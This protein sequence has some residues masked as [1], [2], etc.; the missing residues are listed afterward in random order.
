MAESSLRA[1]LLHFTRDAV[2]T[3]D[4]IAAH[5]AAVDDVGIQR[6]G[7][8][9]RILRRAY[10]MPFAERDLAIV[11][12][13]GDARRSA[14][15]LPAIDP[16][17]H[18]VVGNHVIK[19]RGRLVVPGTPGA[20][21]VHADG[22]ALVESQQDDV[23]ILR[24]DPDGVIVVAA[25]RA[26]DGREARAGVGGPVSGS[27]GDVDHVLVLRVDTHAGEIRSASVDA[28]L[29]V[30]F[31]PGNAGVIGAIEAG[32]TRRGF[33][34][35]RAARASTS[36]ARATRGAGPTAAATSAATGGFDQGIH[37]IAIAG[38]DADADAAEPL[39]GRGQA[40]SQLA[41]VVAAVGGL[42]QAAVRT[43]ESAVL[44]WPGTRLP[45]HGVHVARVGRVEGQINRAG[46]L[47]L[48]KNLAPVLAAIDGAKDAALGVGPER[49]AHR[50]DENAVGVLGI[51]QNCADLLGIAQPEMPPRLAAVDG[52]V[53]AVADGEIGPLRQPFAAADIEHVGVG[54][55]HGDGADGAGGLVIEN[56]PPCHAEIVG[57]PYA[58]VVDADEEHVRLVGD[59]R[60]AD[61]AAAAERADHAPLKSGVI[62]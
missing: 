52:F 21:V 19:L 20:A 49:V 28:I 34:R 14:L 30:D 57:L 61:G 1:D 58:A 12:A 53:H 33:G 31:L 8:N 48:V 39:G 45:H 36:R 15:L 2:P 56:G 23:G 29:A 43:G 47:I 37:A 32:A 27:V 41:P 40:S 50:R 44:P 54:G 6:V 42:E 26:L 16:V 38:R 35:F 59:A 9:V 11:A 4:G 3:G 22:R 55:R 5:A 25:G 24:I 7:R 17:G 10:R 62:F 60:G 13:A 51:N 18:L 46:V